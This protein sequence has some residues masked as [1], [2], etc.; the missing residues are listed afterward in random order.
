MSSGIDLS[1]VHLVCHS[2]QRAGG[3]VSLAAARE[4]RSF[5][6]LGVRGAAHA[7]RAPPA[8]CEAAPERRA[9]FL[10][11]AVRWPLSRPAAPQTAPGPGLSV[12]RL[13]LAYARVVPAT[14][15]ELF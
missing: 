14:G 4:Q 3:R 7:V 6:G 10:P 2:K 9:A 12:A 15:G 13:L 8:H 1:C 11:R 5:S